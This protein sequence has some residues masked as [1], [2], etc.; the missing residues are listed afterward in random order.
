M[1][2]LRFK[3]LQ[4]KFY[5]WQDLEFLRTVRSNALVGD[6]LFSSKKITK[7]EQ[8]DWFQSVYSCDNDYHIWLIYHEQ[9]KC[10]IGYVTI[11]IDS[12]IHRR[13]NFNYIISPEFNYIKCDKSIIN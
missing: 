2:K 5:I 7:V 6:I 13:L 11:R 9:K 3:Y 4:K 8:E 1:K 12:I 10:P